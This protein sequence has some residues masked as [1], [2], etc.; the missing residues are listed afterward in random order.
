MSFEDF[1]DLLL[2]SV[3]ISVFYCNFNLL[4][5]VQD[6]LPY[7]NTDWGECDRPAPFEQLSGEITT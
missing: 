1:V 4:K 5:A 7:Y 2:L 6:K 3:V